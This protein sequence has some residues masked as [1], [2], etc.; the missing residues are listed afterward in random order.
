[1]S[2]PLSEGACGF[3]SDLTLDDMQKRL[4]VK[5]NVAWRGGDNDHWGEYISAWLN[6]NLT[7]IR[8]FRD[9]DR[10]VLDISS[11]DPAPGSLPYDDVVAWAEREVLPTV[12]ARDLAVNRGWE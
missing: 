2:T 10:Y 8:I 3:R 9:R 1:M 4:N 6:D 5:G 11:V 12:E 7:R